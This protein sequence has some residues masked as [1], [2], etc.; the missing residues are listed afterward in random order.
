MMAAFALWGDVPLAIPIGLPRWVAARWHPACST[1]HVPSS[2]KRTTSLRFGALFPSWP[3]ST[4]PGQSGSQ[5]S[6]TTHVPSL[7]SRID[8]RPTTSIPI[9][10]SA[11]RPLSPDP[12]SSTKRTGWGG[13]P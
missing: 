12:L 7:V 2:R 10:L 8:Q 5:P 4:A 1:L 3:L 6:N 13:Q 11:Y 9:A